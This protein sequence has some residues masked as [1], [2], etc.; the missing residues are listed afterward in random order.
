M[1]KNGSPG[2]NLVARLRAHTGPYGSGGYPTGSDIA[3]SDNVAV[4]GVSTSD[5][6][7]TFNFTGSNRVLLT[8]GT[9][10]V[11]I[12]DAGGLTGHDSSN[13]ILFKI[14]NN[15]NHNGNFSIEYSGSWTAVTGGSDTYNDYLFSIYGVSPPTLTT[16]APSS[17][18]QTTATGNGE[19]TNLDGESATTRGFVYMAGTSGTPTLANSVSSD[20]GTFSTGAYTKNYNRF[21]I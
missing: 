8:N 17:V 21:V 18:T 10:Y 4:S 5:S 20:S 16:S 1:K 9:P 14:D 19:I 2:G 6:N 13:R 11:L 12:V 7:V 3:V 15:S